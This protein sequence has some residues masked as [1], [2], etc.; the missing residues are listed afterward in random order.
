MKMQMAA[1]LQITGPIQSLAKNVMA[2]V[3]CILK[4]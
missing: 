1:P 3:P 4:I 2:V